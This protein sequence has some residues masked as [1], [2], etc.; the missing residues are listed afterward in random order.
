MPGHR[1]AVTNTYDI[2]DETEQFTDENMI[3]RHDSSATARC[4]G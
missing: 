4:S 3:D 2:W 1:A